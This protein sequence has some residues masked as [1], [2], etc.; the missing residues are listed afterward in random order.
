MAYYG[1][2]YSTRQKAILLR[3]LSLLAQM[4]SQPGLEGLI[5]NIV[6]EMGGI[7]AEEYAQLLRVVSPSLQQLTMAPWYRG[8]LG[9]I[10]ETH[11]GIG[12]AGQVFSTLSTDEFCAKLFAGNVYFT[13]LTTL[14]LTFG[15]PSHGHHL[16]RLLWSCPALEVL[17]YRG[18]GRG[19]VSQAPLLDIPHLPR[20][21][22]ILYDST[23]CEPMALCK[24]LVASTPNLVELTFTDSRAPCTGIHRLGDHPESEVDVSGMLDHLEKLKVVKWRYGG[25]SF[26]STMQNEPPQSV[27]IL[28]VRSSLFSHVMELPDVSARWFSTYD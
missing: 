13:S 26:F 2:V 11:G 15:G 1:S 3:L 24:A 8:D 14:V 27:E 6:I 23:D 16:A 20:L 12:G 25:T 5:E 18:G 28:A 21:R 22:S 19:S 9:V 10:S 4:E 17:S 7:A